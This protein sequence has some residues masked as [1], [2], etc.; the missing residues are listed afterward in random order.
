VATKF[1][2]EIDIAE[3]DG[4]GVVEWPSKRSPRASLFG[5]GHANRVRRHRELAGN[6][7]GRCGRK[8]RCLSEQA[9]VALEGRIGQD[10]GVRGFALCRDI[11]P[12]AEGAKGEFQ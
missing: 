10:D 9:G 7:S 12:C 5:R 8:R 11:G 1:I 6:Q 4:D 3:S 2:S